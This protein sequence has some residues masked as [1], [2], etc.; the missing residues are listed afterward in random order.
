MKEM[1]VVL[2]WRRTGT[3]CPY[4]TA[5]TGLTLAELLI[6]LIPVLEENGVAVEVR[7]EEAGEGSGVFFN[8]VPLDDLLAEAA[9]AE[10]YCAGPSRME[11]LGNPALTFDPNAPVGRVL[12]EIFFRKAVLLA[13]EE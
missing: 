10:R 12:P 7:V 5:D 6:E 13:L 1:F 2:W 8:G 3:E 4:R 9:G 11:E